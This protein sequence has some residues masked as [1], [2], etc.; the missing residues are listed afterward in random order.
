MARRRGRAAI[1]AVVLILV[2]PIRV[3]GHG[4]TAGT[5]IS[6][7]PEEV[8]A[9]GTVELAG[10]GLEPDS[11]RVINLVGPD[12]VVPFDMVK[13]DADGMFNVTLTIP[14]HLPAG[15]Y[16]F[17][18]IG[19]ETLTT[20]LK[21]DAATGPAAPEPK[22]EAVAVVVARDRSLLE[23]VFLGAVILVA[24]VVG[25]LLVTRA[26]WFGR[27]PESRERPGLD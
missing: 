24:L 9:G 17:Q 22:N 11:D 5:G 19:D 23:N 12:V 8:A 20:E 2:L 4:G 27:V 16:T 6:C 18:A 26:E 15:T 25:F 1:A 13:T 10:N 3:L 21:V 7:E 14:S